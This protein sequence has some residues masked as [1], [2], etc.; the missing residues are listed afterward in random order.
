[1]EFCFRILIP[2]IF[3]KSLKVMHK[4]KSNNSIN[5]AEAKV[6][7]KSNE[8]MSISS[9][10]NINFICHSKNFVFDNLFILK[11][12]IFSFYIIHYFMIKCD[13]DEYMK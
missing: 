2:D 5:D 1:M 13:T 11:L 10:E 8:K 12:D 6:M 7:R 4:E 9:N 3:R